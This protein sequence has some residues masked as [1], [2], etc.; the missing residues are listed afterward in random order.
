MEQ[1]QVMDLPCSLVIRR[2]PLISLFVNGTAKS[3]RKRS[4]SSRCSSSLRS[5]FEK[6]SG[7]WR[8][9]EGAGALLAIRSYLTTARK[10]GQGMLDVLVAAF[11]GRPWMP[12]T[13]GP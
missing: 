11:E 3:R 10:Q 7:G 12:A 4:T 13:A 8:S 5:R 6:I 2:S 9:M 1:R